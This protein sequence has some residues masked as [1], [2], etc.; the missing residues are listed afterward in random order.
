M[1]FTASLMVWVSAK[2]I[3]I[4]LDDNSTDLLTSILHSCSNFLMMTGILDRCYMQFWHWSGFAN[5][6]SYHFK[7]IFS[8]SNISEIDS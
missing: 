4:G 6:V 3:E 7:V 8:S 2:E 5:P 1:D